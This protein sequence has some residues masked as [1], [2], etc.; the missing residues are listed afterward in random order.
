[1]KKNN[2]YKWTIGAVVVVLL[3]GGVVALAHGYR[4]DESPYWGAFMGPLP[5]EL[6]GIALRA[7]D[8]EYAMYAAYEAVI[9]QYGK[10]E[11][12]YTLKEISE[13]NIE[14]LE[15]FLGR[16]NVAYPLE[17]PYLDQ[18]T[19]PGSLEEI[20]A[21]LAQRAAEKGALYAEALRE[22]RYPRGI[23]RLFSYLSRASLKWELPTLELA[24]QSG[25]KLTPSQMADLGFGTGRGPFGMMDE[26][27]DGF[28]SWHDAMWGGRMGMHGYGWGNCH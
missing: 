21:E 3:I 26:D 20:A 14:L 1:M 15:E 19:L 24:A 17:N 5:A 7:L 23:E 2:G 8:A 27:E 9:A 10:I 13:H 16:Y 11:P 25:G 6:E 28:C 22:T 4:Q 18:T 12:Y